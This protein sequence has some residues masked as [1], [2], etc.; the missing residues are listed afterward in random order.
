MMSFKKESPLKAGLNA[1]GV[2]SVIVCIKR[3]SGPARICQCIDG[4]VILG[5]SARIVSREMKCK[6]KYTALYTLRT[7][8]HSA[9]ASGDVRPIS[10]SIS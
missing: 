10:A 1:S 8:K 4:C 6:T 9:P 3:V 2:N 7:I 5:E